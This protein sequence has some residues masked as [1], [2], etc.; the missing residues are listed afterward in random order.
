LSASDLKRM[1]DDIDDGPEQNDDEPN[2][3]VNHE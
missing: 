1:P 2:S 3:K